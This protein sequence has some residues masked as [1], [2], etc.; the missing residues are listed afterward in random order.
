MRTLIFFCCC[1]FLT[2][3]AS[4]NRPTQQTNS[5]TRIRAG[6]WLSLHGKTVGSDLALFASHVHIKLQV[7]D[8]VSAR[9]ANFEAADCSWADAFNDFL[10][11]QHLTLRKLSPGVYSVV[12]ERGK[13]THPA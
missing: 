8:D 5:T 10:I 12:L 11:T 13:S 2:S 6:T 4:A 3:C 1:A 9:T 7:P